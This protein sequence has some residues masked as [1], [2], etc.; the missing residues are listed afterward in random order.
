V[1]DPDFPGDGGARLALKALEENRP[2]W[3]VLSS[4]ED[5]SR[6][7]GF[8]PE[9]LLISIQSAGV[10]PLISL[11]IYADVILAIEEANYT[12]FSSADT[13]PDS[14]TTNDRLISVAEIRDF[15]A[16]ILLSFRHPDSSSW[17]ATYTNV[18]LADTIADFDHPIGTRT[19]GSIL[20]SH[21]RDVGALIQKQIRSH[22]KDHGITGP[23]SLV[24]SGIDDLASRIFGTIDQLGLTV[25]DADLVD[26]FIGLVGERTMWGYVPGVQRPAD[27]VDNATR[28][29]ELLVDRVNHLMGVGDESLPAST[30]TSTFIA[31][32]PVCSAFLTSYGV[33][34]QNN[35]RHLLEQT[36]RLL[37]LAGDAAAVDG[38][39]PGALA[40]AW[41]DLDHRMRPAGFRASDV[42]HA[43]DRLHAS[44]RRL[45]RMV[46]EPLGNRNEDG[47]LEAARETTEVAASTL[48][49]LRIALG[50]D[51]AVARLIE[52]V[53]RGDNPQAAL[54]HIVQESEHRAISIVVAEAAGVSITG[55]TKFADVFNV[56]DAVDIFLP[57]ERYS[58]VPT[59]IRRILAESDPEHLTV[60]ASPEL[61]STDDDQRRLPTDLVAD[62]HE[63]AAK[64][65]QF[66]FPTGLIP[67]LKALSNR[68]GVLDDLYAPLKRGKWKAAMEDRR[69]N[70]TPRQ[71]AG[72][73]NHPGSQQSGSAGDPL[74]PPR[75]KS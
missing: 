8:N 58:E 33:I 36:L 39:E 15:V 22:L 66:V 55:R 25:I 49:V 57:S 27:W 60:I 65:G 54:A 67:L 21:R 4:R 6:I 26:S 75:P 30:L 23:E 71:D 69:V 61:D 7:T 13:D 64:K 17:L 44:T 42:R 43:V 68:E 10:S 18:Y 56:F 5:D 41:I 28:A 29:S 40:R 16:Q 31:I 14:E 50:A 52:A 19:D 3:R 9:M 2:K 53:Q 72:K 63:T 37:K 34:P 1:N 32:A 46:N 51:R 74:S 62:L 73:Q 48:T 59:A 70:R 35:P 47:Q 24:A 12:E 45:F 20:V 38:E 11:K